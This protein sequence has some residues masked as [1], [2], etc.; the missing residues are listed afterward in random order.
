MKNTKYTGIALLV[1]LTACGD[2]A[3]PVATP[4]ASLTNVVASDPLPATTPAPD[5]APAASV[6]SSTCSL[7]STWSTLDDYSYTSGKD[8]YANGLLIDTHG[9]ILSVGKSYDSSNTRHWVARTSLNNGASWSNID[10]FVNSG[11][12]SSNALGAFLDSSN[13]L[14]VVGTGSNASTTPWLIRKGT[15]SSGS[16]STVDS[17]ASTGA[18]QAIGSDASGNLYAVGY[19]DSNWVVRKSTDSGSSWTI[20]DNYT[21]GAVAQAFVHDSAGNIYVGGT[22]NSSNWIIRKSANSG[23]SWSTVDTYAN[24]QVR[25]MAVDSVGLIYAVGNGGNGWLVRK[26]VDQGY[27]WSTVD[28]YS[29]NSGAGSQA[30]GVTTDS[31]NNVY[32]VG[33]GYD[34]STTHWIVRKGVDSF[35]NIDDFVYSGGT[36]SEGNTIAVDSSGS[37]YAAGFGKDSGAVKHWIVRKLLCQ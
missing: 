10:D 4:T 28:N 27:T 12:A 18:A 13:N 23:V 1:L 24:A 15:E 33:Q 7:E 6:A 20:S 16:F 25:G 5:A 2:D 29:M 36:N 3:A 35:S 17:Y 14:F 21:S 9:D 30:F 37:L 32:V 34:G 26:S 8:S 22:D 11:G 19:G 31:S